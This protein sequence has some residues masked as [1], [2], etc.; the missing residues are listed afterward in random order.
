MGQHLCLDCDVTVR[1]G[2][3]GLVVLEVP[4][5]AGVE[6]VA[7]TVADVDALTN[8]LMTWRAQILL[9]ELPKPSWH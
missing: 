3:D 7:L 6:F 2:D 5:D 9:K 1:K 8:W 4:T